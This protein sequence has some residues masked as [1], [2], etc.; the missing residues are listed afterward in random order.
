MRF[1]VEVAVVPSHFQASSYLVL[2]L[3]ARNFGLNL[4]SLTSAWLFGGRFDSIALKGPR[5][6][7]RA[8]HLHTN[9][10]EVGVNHH[11]D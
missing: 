1:Q 11:A 3:L 4:G 7:A 8:V 10:F 5:A 9:E 2:P 6:R